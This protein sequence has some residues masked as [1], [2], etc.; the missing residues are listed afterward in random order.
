MDKNPECGAGDDDDASDGTWH[1]RLRELAARRLPEDVAMMVG[2]IHAQRSNDGDALERLAG[3]LLFGAIDYR[4]RGVIA[5]IRQR[6]HVRHHA[7]SV[8]MLFAVQCLITATRALRAIAAE[9]AADTPSFG[10]YLNRIS[11]QRLS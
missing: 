8:E 7:N 4:P 2:L 6:R 3:E 11:S 10:L 9:N 1:D 5:R